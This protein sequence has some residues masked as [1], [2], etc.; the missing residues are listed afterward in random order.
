[1]AKATKDLLETLH[2]AVAKLLLDKV[3]SGEVTASEIAQ[4]VKMLK[5]NNIDVSPTGEHPLDHLAG[6]LSDRLPFSSTGDPTV[7]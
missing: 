5:D 3:E 4:A 6:S 2:G 7:N 1:M